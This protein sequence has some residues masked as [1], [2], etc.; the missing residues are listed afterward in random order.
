MKYDSLDVDVINEQ[1]DLSI[2][3][4]KVVEV[5]RTVI[6]FE[7]EACDEVALHFVTAERICELH[8]QFFDDPSLTDCITLPIDEE[9]D[10]MY[11]HLGEVFVC[12]FTAKEYV[13]DHKG[14]E[15]EELTLYIVHGL[16]HLMGYDDIDDADREAMRAAETRHM[17]HLKEKGLCLSL[18]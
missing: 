16:L 11:R 7:G 18:P 10:E 6:S 5:A 4:D 15:Y 1:T 14:N 2:D 3:L 8:D 12:P 17:Q 13:R 9:D